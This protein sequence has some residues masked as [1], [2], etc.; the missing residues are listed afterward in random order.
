MSARNRWFLFFLT[1]LFCAVLLRIAIGGA[2]VFPTDDAYISLHSA[3]H[4]GEAADPSYTSSKP[5]TGATSPL[6]VFVLSA[7]MRAG[8]PPLWAVEG[9]TWLGAAAYL[10]GMASLILR[11]VSSKRDRILLMALASIVCH[12]PMQ[13]ANGQETGWSM[14]AVTWGLNW[15]DTDARTR[16]RLPVLAG[17]MP[18]LRPDLLVFSAALVVQRWR[19]ARDRFFLDAGVTAFLVAAWLLADEHF[20]GALVPNTLTAKRHFFAVYALPWH[21]IALMV[22]YR[23]IQFVGATGPAVIGLIH[24]LREEADRLAA[25]SFIAVYGAIGLS[26]A[27]ALDHNFFRYLH[28]LGVPAI[29]AGLCAMSAARQALPAFWKSIW[30]LFLAASVLYA[31]VYLPRRWGDFRRAQVVFAGMQGSVAKWLNANAPDAVVLVHDAGFLSEFTRTRLVDLVGL[32]TPR[33]AALHRS[34]TGPSAG[35]DRPEAIHRLA[36]ETRPDFYVAWNQ[37]ETRFELTSGLQK[38]GW[39]TTPVMSNEVASPNGP[40]RVSLYRLTPSRRCATALPDG[41]N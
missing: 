19:S 6:H 40:Q 23:S 7:V 37:W 14:A 9:V 3:R 2:P 20:V 12:T 32:K 21:F 41:E 1:P 24:A 8:V 30:P 16:W 13:L 39:S 17:I 36:C 26:A 33:A 5:M 18:W 25:L 35:A 29:I 22:V 15:V 34:I 10:A 4:L 27:I 11:R 38:Y 31:V 28:P